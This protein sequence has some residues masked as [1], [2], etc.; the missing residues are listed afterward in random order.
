[1]LITIAIMCYGHRS[2]QI[3]YCSRVR[4][5]F[6]KNPYDDGDTDMVPTE[7]GHDMT[8]LVKW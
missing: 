8:V 5:Y 1:M 7:S 6:E 2:S 4:F 3:A